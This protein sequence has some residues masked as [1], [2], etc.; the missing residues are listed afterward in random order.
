LVQGPVGLLLQSLHEH[1]AFIDD[2]FIIRAGPVRCLDLRYMPL[3]G[4]KRSTDDLI[5][6]VHFAFLQGNRTALQHAG[7]FNKRVYFD[8]LGK[9]PL[10]DRNLLR[11]AQC[12]ALW[13]ADAD[14][15]KCQVGDGSC[16]FCGSRSAGTIHEVWHCRAFQ[17]EQLAESPEL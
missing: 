2:S 11:S 5:T 14:A 12:L 10:V 6:D 9:V 13:S 4:L 15:K 7:T 17:Q 16:P 8:A 3:Q 1:G